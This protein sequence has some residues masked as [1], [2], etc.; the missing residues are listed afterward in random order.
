MILSNKDTIFAFLILLLVIVLYI[1]HVIVLV[2]Y[3]DKSRFNKRIKAKKYINNID[4]K[5]YSNLIKKDYNFKANNNNNLKG[6]IYY[7]KE[8]Y[9]NII[10]FACGYNMTKEQYIPEI[11]FFASL[12]YTVFCYDNLG[13]GESEG[14]T[15]K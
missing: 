10:I 5:K 8:Q 11:N 1:L 4:Y 15:F 14:K 3:T 7:Y 6:N 12:G 2:I 9:E 13:T